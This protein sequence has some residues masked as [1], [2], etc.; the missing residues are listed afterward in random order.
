MA[1][2]RGGELTPEIVVDVAVQMLETVSLDDLTLTRIAGE[3]GVTQPALYRHLGGIDDLWRQLGLR[4]R[5][6]LAEALT[7]ATIGRSGPDSVEAASRA[8]R[9]FTKVKPGLYAATDRH[10][11]AGDEELEA[12][13]ER[14][15]E[16]LAMSLRGFDLDEGSTIDAARTLR[17]SL[18]GFVHLEMGEGHPHPHDNDASFETMVSMLCVGFEH[19]AEHRA[20]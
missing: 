12:A 4:G 8:W 15:V 17:S 13:V 9:T 14:V 10:P 18:H 3:L 7:E 19:L 20:I 16:V 2:E 6:E 5:A 1:G 11:C